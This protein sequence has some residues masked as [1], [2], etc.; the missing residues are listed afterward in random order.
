MNI[1]HVLEPF[2]I[3]KFLRFEKA[4]WKNLNWW[5]LPLLTDQ[6]QN[7]FKILNLEIKFCEDLAQVEAARYQY[8]AS[9]YIFS[10][11]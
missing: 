2:E 4:N 8:I 10:S 5:V 1:L 3:T 6:V 7:A 11:K 9:C